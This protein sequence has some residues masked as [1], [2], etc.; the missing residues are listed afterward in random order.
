MTV[1]P[2]THTA[3]KDR[4]DAVEMPAAV[5]AHLRLDD[6]ASWV[7]VT[8]TNDFIWPGYNL[9]PVP[10]RRPRRYHYGMLPPRFF[11]TVR[12]RI[13]QAH[14]DRRLQRVSRTE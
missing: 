10:G 14:L 3:P 2:V 12:D 11:A 1:V 6:L 8:E 5:K 9:R 4:A 13:L 7:A